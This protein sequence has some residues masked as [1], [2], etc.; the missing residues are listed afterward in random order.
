MKHTPGPWEA[1]GLQIFESNR[2]GKKPN[3]KI[4]ELCHDKMGYADP[5]P[6]EAE[7]AANARLVAA[8]PALLEAL[9]N[10]NHKPR[11]DEWL[12]E[13]AFLGAMRHYNQALEAIKKAT[14]P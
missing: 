4:A 6:G 13:A 5:A 12:N 7:Q 10:V 8:A 2:A 1:I 3:R 14:Q 9:I 11:R